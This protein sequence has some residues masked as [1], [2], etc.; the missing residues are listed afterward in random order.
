V[1]CAHYHLHDEGEPCYKV[2]D[3]DIESTRQNIKLTWKFARNLYK[4]IQEDAVEFDN[5][6]MSL[7]EHRSSKLVERKKQQQQRRELVEWSQ[8][9]EEKMACLLLKLEALEQ[10]K[11]QHLEKGKPLDTKYG[12]REKIM[13][14]RITALQEDHHMAWNCYHGVHNYFCKHAQ[15]K[16]V[17]RD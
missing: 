15:A 13:R 10:I 12:E 11:A 2:V 4:C 8:M 17:E 9:K 14:S 1:R 5:H 3:K 6:M 16:A 7:I